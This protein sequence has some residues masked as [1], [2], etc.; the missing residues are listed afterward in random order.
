MATERTRDFLWRAYSEEHE[1]RRHL[2]SAVS[3]PAG[4]LALCTG[5]FAYCLKT[6]PE[7]SCEAGTALLHTLLLAA[8]V[9]FIIA[10]YN[11]ARS[12]HGHEYAYLP[13]VARLED[14][15]NAFVKYLAGSDAALP[16]QAHEVRADSE[17][18]GA[19]RDYLAE[20]ATHNRAVNTRRS[21][22]L[23][24]ANKFTLI[25]LAMLGSVLIAHAVIQRSSHGRGPEEAGDAR[26]EASVTPAEA[27]D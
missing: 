18:E 27:A 9:S 5:G 22:Y 17:V 13:N 3:I 7:F 23:F 14:Y 24:R 15:R 8:G 11:L 6:F 16:S 19:V 21:G 4:F 20:C 1:Q 12:I 26:P 10:A 25:C 2:V